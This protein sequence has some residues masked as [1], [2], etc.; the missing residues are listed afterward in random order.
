MKE[1]SNPLEME[2]FKLNKNIDKRTLNKCIY[3]MNEIERINEEYNIT[4]VNSLMNEYYKIK[5][6]LNDPEN[7]LKLISLMNFANKLVFG[8]YARNTQ[9]ISLLFF[10]NKPNNEGLIQQVMTGEGKSLIISF[11][12]VFINLVH[13]KKVDILTSSI[14]LAQRDCLLYKN[15][16]KLFDVKTDFC[17]DNLDSETI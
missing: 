1:A 7:Q 3:Q 17:R 4:E 12:A 10:I 9:L 13:K 8:Y 6:K 2:L 5:E 15:F 11:L 14:I 16:Y